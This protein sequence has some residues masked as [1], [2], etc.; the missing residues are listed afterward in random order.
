[1]EEPMQT[2]FPTV[3]LFFNF[4]FTFCK[5][6][7]YK[8]EEAFARRVLEQHG[9]EWLSKKDSKNWYEFDTRLLLSLVKDAVPKMLADALPQQHELAQ[10]TCARLEIEQ[11]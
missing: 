7:V 3:E 2:N 9:V 11:I 10:M 8:T 5:L 4:A 1:M 6:R